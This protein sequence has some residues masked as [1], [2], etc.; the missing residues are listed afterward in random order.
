MSGEVESAAADSVGHLVGGRHKSPPAPGATCANCDAVLQG[1]FCHVCG[2][3]ADTHKRS[4]LHLAWEALEDLFHLDGRLLRTLPD[5]FFRP[6]RLARDYMESRIARHVPPFRTFLVALLLFIFAAEHATHEAA[7][8]NEREAQ[9]R[10]AALATP[11][12]RTVEVARIRQEAAQERA[13]DL[14]EA[15]NDRLDNLKDPDDNRTRTEAAYARETLRAQNR[16]AEALGNADRIAKGL[17]AEPDVAVTAGAAGSV[18]KKGG[19]FK[20]GLHKATANPEYYLAV[21]FTWGHRIAVLLLPIVG[22]SLALVYVGKRRFFIYDHLLVAMNLLSFAFLT[23]A[24]GFVL[25]WPLAAYWFGVVAIWTP[26]NLFQT[27]RGAYGSSVLGAVLKTLV[28]WTTT[29]FSFGVLLLAV[30]VLSLAQL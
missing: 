11:K 21:M 5:L 7:K 29:V 10:A 8:Q 26:I 20:A 25:P 30:L 3:N 18:A 12:G 24:L 6:G 1:P 16:Y 9:I 27:L 19:W 14:K 23:N 28:V 4:I 2:Q 22:L 17:S 15:A 13:D